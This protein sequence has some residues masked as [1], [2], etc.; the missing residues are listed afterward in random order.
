MAAQGAAADALDDVTGS[1]RFH[2]NMGAG[3]RLDPLRALVRLDGGDRPIIGSVR[4]GQ[5]T[6]FRVRRSFWSCRTLLR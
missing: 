2:R 4:Q 3:W 1:G 5:A 6:P